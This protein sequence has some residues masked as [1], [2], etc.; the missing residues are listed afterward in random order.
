MNHLAW[1][2]LVADRLSALREEADRERLIRLAR[3]PDRHQG[4]TEPRPT[5]AVERC[6]E[7]AA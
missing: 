7:P 1:A 6:P 4:T 5:R 3:R 2:I